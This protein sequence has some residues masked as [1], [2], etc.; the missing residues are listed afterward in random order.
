[1]LEIAGSAD[2]A[3]ENFLDACVATLPDDVCG[4]IN[5]VV[6]WSNTGAQLHNKIARLNLQILGALIQLRFLTTPKAVPF[7]RNEPNQSRGH[8]G[9]PG[10]SRS[11]QLRK[12]QGRHRADW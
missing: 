1:M 12:L 9:R 11:N 6:R 2:A 4:K 3:V 8:S 5:L 10:K 7:C